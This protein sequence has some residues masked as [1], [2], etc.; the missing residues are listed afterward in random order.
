MI[1]TGTRC[2]LTDAY[3]VHDFDTATGLYVDGE[4]PLRRPEELKGMRGVKEV[5]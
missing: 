3:R 5:R 1:C 4:A 2:R